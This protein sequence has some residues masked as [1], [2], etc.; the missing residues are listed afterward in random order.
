MFAGLEESVEDE[1]KGLTNT[2]SSAL[3]SVLPTIF[4]KLSFPV[5]EHRK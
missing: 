1:R 4:E 3:L 2:R 5:T